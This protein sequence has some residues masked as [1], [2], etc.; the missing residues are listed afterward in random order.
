MTATTTHTL[1]DRIAALDWAA[2]RAD[3]DVQGFAETEPV[4]TPD[5]YA[6]LAAAFDDDDRFRSTIDMR[7]H[8]FGE[9]RYRYFDHPLPA[10]VGE[11][12]RAFY[13]P[14]AD[15]AN[16]WADRLGSDEAAYPPDLDAFLKR[17]HAVGQRRPTPLLLR[18]EAGGHNALHQ[19]LYG[20]VAFPFQVV[21]VLN[22]PGRD[23]EGGQFVL[24]EQRPRA[25]SRAHVIDLRQGAFAIFPTRHRPVEGKRGYYRVN[26]RHGVATVRSGERIT[27]GI[28]F[29]DAA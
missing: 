4:Y 23:F 14:L 21:T 16:A 3:L 28:I 9:G 24:L 11:V 26:L 6:E 17:C 13:P 5:E 22:R 20:A 1:A 2:L 29:H 19:D 7:R 25:Q 15:T 18:Y 8:R 10:L 12:R 27:L